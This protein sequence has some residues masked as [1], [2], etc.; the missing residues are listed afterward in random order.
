[1]INYEELDPKCV[2]MVKYFNENG[3]PTCMCC[4]GHPERE[5][6]ENLSMSLFWIEFKWTVSKRAIEKFMRK[7]ATRYPKGTMTFW[8][9]G[10]FVER[11]GIGFS[12]YRYVA[13]NPEAAMDDLARWKAE[14][15]ERERKEREGK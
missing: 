9:N 3:L 4:Q 14:D 11:F 6:P 12:E 7:H 2:E 8:C 1:M 10:E 5:Y 13:A 15:Q